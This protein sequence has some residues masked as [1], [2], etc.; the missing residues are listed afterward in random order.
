[1]FSYESLTDA[2]LI[3]HLKDG[4]HSA[5]TE[6]YK[7]FWD[8]IFTVAYHRL[9]DQTEAE[10]VVQDVFFSLWK[11][12]DSLEIQFSLNTYLSAAVKYQVINRQSRRYLKGK[13]VELSD[14][15]D[16]EGVDTTQLWFSERELKQQ[17]H[18][19][20]N[21]LP[22]KCRLVFKMSREQYMSYAEIAK[23][24]GVSEKAVEANIT[25][26]L[27]ILRGKLHMGIPLICYLLSK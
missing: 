17:L 1:M 3:T 2:E 22:E 13:V 10:E 12:R 27:K 14:A 24:L 23:E 6:I 11:R 21:Q 19:H 16:D 5:F 7:R 15:F 8:K 20:I 25:R 18:Y 4:D 26:A 9:E